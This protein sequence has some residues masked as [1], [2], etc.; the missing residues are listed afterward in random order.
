MESFGE[1]EEEEFVYFKD[2]QTCLYMD[3]I[4]TDIVIYVNYRYAYINVDRKSKVIA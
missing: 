1:E 2:F 4:F 3:Y